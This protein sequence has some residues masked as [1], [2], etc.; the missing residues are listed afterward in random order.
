MP[1]WGQ[2]LD[3]CARNNTVR[4]HAGLHQQPFRHTQTHTL[5]HNHSELE[6]DS[7]NLLFGWCI[8]LQWISAAMQENVS[9]IQLNWDV[10][11]QCWADSVLWLAIL[12]CLE[13]STITT[14]LWHILNVSF[15]CLY[16]LY[17]FR[18][19]RHHHRTVLRPGR[20][21]KHWFVIWSDN[22]SR[23]CINQHVMLLICS[24]PSVS[25]TSKLNL[26]HICHANGDKA[27]RLGF[28]LCNLGDERNR[29]TP[30]RALPKLF[31]HRSHTHQR[32]LSLAPF[33]PL[34]DVLIKAEEDHSTT[35]LSPLGRPVWL[36][37]GDTQLAQAYFILTQ[38]TDWKKRRKRGSKR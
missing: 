36:Q 15:I 1:H 33:S 6:R 8:L 22:L 21:W 30:E 29:T 5:T 27:H 25:C 13:V 7:N 31:K 18:D 23:Y 20:P 28:A 2:Q 11:G 37:T 24:A 17:L 35:G 14:T 19:V 9:T 10:A 4:T 12:S 3:E 16:V 38:G 26:I 32:K 34:R